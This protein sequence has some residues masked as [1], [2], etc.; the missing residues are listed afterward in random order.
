MTISELG[1]IGE[2]IGAIATVATLLYLA[3][4]IRANTHQAKYNAIND[5]IDRINKWQS[6]IADTPD[7]MKSWIEGTKNYQALSIE[8]QV[9]FTST[10]V[11]ILTGIEAALES[12]KTDGIKQESVAAVKVMVHQLM[13]NKGVREYWLI[14]GRNLFAQDFV[15]VVDEILEAASTADPKDA[16]P[17]PFYMPAPTSTG[18]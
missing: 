11:E 15:V 7:L 5:I 4:Q 6:R 16:G 12:A 2:L 18:G 14:S 1:S 17:A 3:L 9:R 10:A 13:R 8:D